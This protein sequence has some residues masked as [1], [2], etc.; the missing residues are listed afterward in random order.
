LL[1]FGQSIPNTESI[2][3]SDNLGDSKTFTIKKIA[4]TFETFNWAGV[5]TISISAASTYV[6]DNLTV[7]G[8]APGSGGGAPEPSTWAMLLIGFAGLSF[9]SYRGS[10]RM[11]ANTQ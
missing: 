2:T 1:P 6:F 3:V 9:A 4:P 7:G 5:T 11:T 8:I 10:R